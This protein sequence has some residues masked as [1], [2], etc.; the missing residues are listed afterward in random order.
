MHFETRISFWLGWLS[1]GLES[2][3]R[4]ESRQ[5]VGDSLI[6]VVQLTA[7]VGGEVAIAGKGRAGGDRR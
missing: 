7:F 3:C 2:D 1:S 5:I 4:E 6:E